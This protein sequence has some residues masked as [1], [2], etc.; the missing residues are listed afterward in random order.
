[1]DLLNILNL[2]KKKKIYF[3]QKLY[4][5]ILYY[6]VLFLKINVIFSLFINYCKVYL[7]FFKPNNI[8]LRLIL[9]FSMS[10]NALRLLLKL[11]LK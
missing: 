6:K 5:V 11:D 9:N 10:L 4:T 1:M 2:C 8:K 7:N 3:R